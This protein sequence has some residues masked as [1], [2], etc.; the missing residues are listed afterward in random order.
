MNIFYAKYLLELKHQFTISYNS[1]KTTPVVLVKIE[2]NGIAAYG[3]ASLP[4]Y[5]PENQE[6]VI[7]YLTEFSHIIKRGYS[8]IPN[9]YKL[10]ESIPVQNNPAKAAIDIALHDLTGKKEKKT[11]RELLGIRSNS[12]PYTSYTIGIDSPEG[13]RNKIEAAEEYKYLKI[14]IGT[15]DDRRIISQVRE[16]TDKPIYVDVN[17][18]WDN[19]NEAFEMSKWLADQ[20]VKLI[21]QPFKKYNLAGSQWLS[22]RSPIP[23]IADEDAQSL[24]DLEV[25]KNS[26]N[27]INIKLMKCAGINEALKMINYAKKN[28]LKIMLGC[29]TETS[30]AISA[31]SQLA[32]AADFIDLDG[33]A[34]ISNDPFSGHHASDGK[35]YLSDKSGLGIDLNKEIEFIKL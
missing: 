15:K 3:E 18:G 5:L 27:G 33:N 2:E 11:C 30:S 1:R 25:I 22:E 29:M 17:Q 35:I 16:I 32:S 13:M 6:T 9:I 26:F 21:E 28:N 31:A 4:P 24:A 12:L 10:M 7:N 8:D 20:N 23:I 19:L 14:K 34:L